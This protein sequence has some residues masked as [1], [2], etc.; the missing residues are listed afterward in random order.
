M[1]FYE[2]KRN[3]S[4]DGLPLELLVRGNTKHGAEEPKYFSLARL[5]SLVLPRYEAI[6]GVLYDRG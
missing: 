3:V 5:A 1:G 6:A 4:L 2:S